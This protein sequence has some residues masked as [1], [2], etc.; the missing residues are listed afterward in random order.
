MTPQDKP[1]F[2][3]EDCIRKSRIIDLGCE[4][5]QAFGF[6][7]ERISNWLSVSWYLFPVIT[8]LLC[9]P[10]GEGSLF[11][12]PRE[13]G[14]VWYE[15]I[16]N[17]AV[18]GISSPMCSGPQPFLTDKENVLW[19]R[20][21]HSHSINSLSSRLLS[22]PS[23]AFPSPAHQSDKGE[24]WHWPPAHPGLL[25]SQTSKSGFH[26]CFHRVIWGRWTQSAR[27]VCSH[28]SG[29]LCCQWAVFHKN[30]LF[31]CVIHKKCLTKISYSSLCQFSL[32]LLFLLSEAAS[33][34]WGII[35]EDH[36]PLIE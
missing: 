30:Y 15:K 14:C 6:W 13:L 36:L 17:K 5:V 11:Y 32:G 9:A 2:F 33:F 22:T 4:T 25:Q 28:N 18:P 12:S 23:S 1:L 16:S 20:P 26:I 24:S 31:I 19:V 29:I 27:G 21:W 35:N 10:I 34:E 8:S 7:K 3:L